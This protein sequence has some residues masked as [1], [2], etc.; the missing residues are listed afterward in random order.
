M[1]ARYV[2]SGF[3][4]A[5]MASCSLRSLDSLDD[6]RGKGGA[7]AGG[8]A[9]DG[10][11][12]GAPGGTAPSGGGNATGGDPS[13]PSTA[14]DGG[15]IFHGLGGESGEQPTLGG[16]QG[17]GGASTTD[18]AESGSGG[19]SDPASSG[20]GGA[21]GSSVNECLPF[22]YP[23][24]NR[25]LLRTCPPSFAACLSAKTESYCRSTY[26]HKP[27][28]TECLDATR[29]RCTT[30]HGCAD[31]AGAYQCC[32]ST[33]NS[34]AQEQ[35]EYFACDAATIENEACPKLDPAC[36]CSGTVSSAGEILGH[37]LPVQYS[38]TW[39]EKA[40]V[41]LLFT[42]APFETENT[43][44]LGLLIYW[45]PKENQR[46]YPG[47]PCRVI[48]RADPRS[49]TVA[50]LTCAIELDA[51]IVFALT[52]QGCDGRIK[53]TVRVTNTGG[54]GSGGE[55]SG[56]EGSGGEGSGGEGSGGEGSGGVSTFKATFDTPFVVAK[57]E[58]LAMRD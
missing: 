17:L 5:L 43:G 1:R 20:S 34:C 49:E 44:A 50:D 57:T 15:A 3:W 24:P 51:P 29:R 27:L 10:G 19:E 25:A 53:G 23:E 14:G 35:D 39:I 32:R 56:G 22:V 31:A 54:G 7:P 13:S 52:P 4:L 45:K 48:R 37:A 6:N 47:N 40:N 46:S 41:G 18:P 16:S 55:G 12:P 26:K 2:C 11:S 30:Q 36:T 33:A 58:L 38:Y 28:C 9:S 21:G 42:N 8:G